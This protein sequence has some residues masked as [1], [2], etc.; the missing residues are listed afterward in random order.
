[1]GNAEATP[2]LPAASTPQAPA[3]S[4]PSQLALAALAN[5]LSGDTVLAYLSYRA[6]GGK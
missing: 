6:R 1:M 2:T 5:G 3:L 4:L